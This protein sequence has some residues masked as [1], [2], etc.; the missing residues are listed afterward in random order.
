[1]GLQEIALYRFEAQS[2]YVGGPLPPPDAEDV[3]LDFLAILT[4][5][6]EA[7]GLSYTAAS[8]SENMDIELPMC[9]TQVCFPLAD[10]R[11]TD[12]DVVLVRNDV[13]FDN[14]ADGNF[15]AQLPIEV[16]GQVI[17]KPSG[18]ASVDIEFKNNSYRFVNA[19]LEPA[20]VLPGGGVHPDIAYIQAMQLAELLAIVDGSPHPVIMVGD[21][22]SDDD[23][24]TTPTYQDVVNAGFVDAWLIGRPRGPGYTSNQSP[25]LLNASSQLFHRIDFVFYRDGFTTRTGSFR[26]SVAAELLGEAQADRTESGLWPSDHAGLAATLRIAPGAK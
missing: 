20:D 5:A 23:G 14:A 18:W 22:N 2:D 10:I 11:L 9:T 1:V 13:V 15:A 24:S 7:R 4:D 3:L 12:Y 25:D 19:H 21:F 16:G 26:G 6:L 17:F 8:K